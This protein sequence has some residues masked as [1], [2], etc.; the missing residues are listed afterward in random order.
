MLGTKLPE[1]ACLKGLT[2]KER[3]FVHGVEMIFAA[4]ESISPFHQQADLGR[5]TATRLDGLPD[6]LTPQHQP[7]LRDRQEIMCRPKGKVLTDTL[8]AARGHSVQERAQLNLST[9][10]LV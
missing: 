4:R 3:K 10:F 6:C 1:C 9:L 8:C 7:C 5:G 2:T